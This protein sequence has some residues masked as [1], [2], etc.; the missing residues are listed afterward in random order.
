MTA[1]EARMT[2]EKMVDELLLYTVQFID[3][4]IRATAERGGTSFAYVLD[5][6]KPPLVKQIVDTYQQRGFSLKMALPYLF[7][8]WGEEEEEGWLDRLLGSTPRFE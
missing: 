4:Q 1:D 3:E 5:M 7:I 2:T 6:D 8:M